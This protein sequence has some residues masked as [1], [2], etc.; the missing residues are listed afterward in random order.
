MTTVPYL[1]PGFRLDVPSTWMVFSSGEAQASFLMPP[2][3]P[4]SAMTLLV[5]LSQIGDPIS[6]EQAAQAARNAQSKNYDGFQEFGSETLSGEVQRVL[7]RVRWQPPQGEAVVQ[8]HLFCVADN[9]LLFALTA[10]RPEA[11]APEQAAAWDAEVEA[12]LRSFT[13]QAPIPQ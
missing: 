2:Y 10:T 8:H 1:G 11:L 7:Q 3:D 13:V 12:A 9:H 6:A 5:R 4:N